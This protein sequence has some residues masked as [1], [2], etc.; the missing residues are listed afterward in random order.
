MKRVIERQRLGW[1]CRGRVLMTGTY[2]GVK[3]IPSCTWVKDAQAAESH[4]HRW[5]YLYAGSPGVSG[6]PADFGPDLQPV[7]VPSEPERIVQEA[8][9]P[10]IC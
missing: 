8:A 4:N 6:I 7:C 1:H 2:C 5:N 3:S 9:E 10:F